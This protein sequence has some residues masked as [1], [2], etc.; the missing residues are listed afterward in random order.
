MPHQ[1][2][3]GNMKT[4]CMSAPLLTSML[5]AFFLGGRNPACVSSGLVTPDHKTG[6]T[7]DPANYRPNRP[8][9]VGQALY[10]LYTIILNA[11]LVDWSEKHSLRSPSQAG[12]RPGRS[13]V[14]HLFAL[15]ALR[16]FIDH[17]KLAKR[18]LYTCCVDLQ[19]AYNTVQHV[20]L[21][22]RLRQIGVSPCMLAASQSLYATATLAMK[23]DGTGG[24]PAVQHM[25]VRQGR[26]HI[27]WHLL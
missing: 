25:G 10:R 23:I 13:T 20:V 2:E 16:H 17:A 1:A 9:A 19:K 11:R 12:F 3:N 7:L 18:A 14:H 22:D 8:I 21:W 5:N 15:L 24:Q 4:I 6:C 27:V 26:P